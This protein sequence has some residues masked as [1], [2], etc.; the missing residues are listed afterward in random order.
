MLGVEAAD[1][2]ADPYVSQPI[3]CRPPPPPGPSQIPPDPMAGRTSLRSLRSQSPHGVPEQPKEPTVP[4][5]PK[6]NDTGRTGK[7]GCKAALPS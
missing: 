6:G 1:A 3:G 4:R 2:H 7:L 5:E